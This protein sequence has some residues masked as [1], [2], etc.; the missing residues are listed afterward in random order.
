MSTDRDKCTSISCT[1]D[2]RTDISKRYALTSIVQLVPHTQNKHTTC[3]GAALMHARAAR[4]ALERSRGRTAWRGYSSTW[5]VPT[6]WTPGSDGVPS[7]TADLAL[8]TFAL[9]ITTSRFPLALLGRPSE[10]HRCAREGPRKVPGRHSG[11]PG[12]AL[13]RPQRGPKNVPGRRQEP[14]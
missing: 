11:G 4:K 12:K 9:A 3:P 2:I 14:Q 1:S 6:P 10:L 7:C 13:R 5:P 8:R